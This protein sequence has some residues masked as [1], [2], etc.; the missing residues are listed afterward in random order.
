MNKK[1]NSESCF[2]TVNWEKAKELIDFRISVSGMGKFYVTY[3]PETTKF[4]DGNKRLATK[5]DDVYDVYMEFGAREIVLKSP[6]HEFRFD[7]EKGL[8]HADQVDEIFR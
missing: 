8:L 3:P 1:G 7:K 5:P 6:N 2:S 4:N